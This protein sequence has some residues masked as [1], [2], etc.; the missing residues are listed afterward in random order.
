M[1]ILNGKPVRAGI[2]QNQKAH[3]Q[4]HSGLF[5]NPSV[6]NNPALQAALQAHIQEHV[7][8]DYQLTMQNLMGGQQIPQPGQPLP[9]EQ[10]NQL[11]EQA[12][13]ATEALV[14]QQTEALQAGQPKEAD[15]TAVLMADIKAKED[16]MNQK[17]QQSFVDAQIDKYKI[18]VDAQL[19]QRDMD[20]RFREQDS[21]QE[22][23]RHLAE[24]QMWVDRMNQE[25]ESIK[26]QV[27]DIMNR[28]ESL[29]AQQMQ[30]EHERQ[31]QEEQQ[32][33]EQMQ[34]QQE[35]AQQQSMGQQNFKENKND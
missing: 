13:Q 25:N 22:H 23:E 4:G 28:F 9:P 32:V 14:Q 8:F 10:E 35:H 29:S 5:T 31:Q 2:E 15:P 26:S 27:S 7:A 17:A 1:D 33:H 3:I 18:D 11:A 6:A 19:K 30:Q 34:Q 24:Q 21:Q 12:A 16:A 20:E